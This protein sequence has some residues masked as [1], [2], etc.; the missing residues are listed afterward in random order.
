M[1][2]IACCLR[3]RGDVHKALAALESVRARERSLPDHVNNATTALNLGSVHSKLGKCVPAHGGCCFGYCCCLSSRH[4]SHREAARFTRWAIQRLEKDDLQQSP[5]SAGIMA[6]SGSG[7]G[8]QQPFGSVRNLLAIRPSNET[9]YASAHGPALAVAYHNLGI[10]LDHFDNREEALQAFA[11]GHKL[12]VKHLGSSH[13]IT[14]EIWRQYIHVRKLQGSAVHIELTNLC[15]RPT[16]AASIVTQLDNFSRRTQLA[17]TIVP[18]S[19]CQ[20]K[21]PTRA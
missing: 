6:L 2:N 20:A 18:R 5:T 1:N 10:E 9:A 11:T 4:R 14:T 12:A 17:S 21:V 15:H 7:R 13:T 19:R 8:R 3:D 16:I